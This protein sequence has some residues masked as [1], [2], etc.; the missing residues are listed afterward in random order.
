VRPLDRA[1][2]DELRDDHVDLLDREA[3]QVGQVGA[4]HHPLD[5]GEHE[6]LEWLEVQRGHVQAIDAPYELLVCPELL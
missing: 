6:S 4:A 2:S 1:H 3:G 5:A